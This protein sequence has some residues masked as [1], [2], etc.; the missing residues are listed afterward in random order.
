MWKSLLFV[1]A[2][3]GCKKQEAPPASSSSGSAGSGSVVGPGSVV[4]PSA[5]PD[6]AASPDAVAALD[7]GATKTGLLAPGDQKHGCFAWSA[8]TRSVACMVGT[9]GLGVGGQ[10]VLAV[11][12]TTVTVVTEANADPNVP[13]S[14]PQLAADGVDYAHE[15]L[16]KGGFAPLTGAPQ[17]VT[18][19][20]L[21]LNGVAF[22]LTAKQTRPGGRMMPPTMKHTLTATCGG[23]P[24]VLEQ[25]EIEG[26]TLKA[27]VRAAGTDHVV[28]EIDGNI[29][30]EGERSD[31]TIAQLFDVKACKG[32]KAASP[33][34]SL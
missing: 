4:N 10:Y 11:V 33:T 31:T 29:G 24:I 6:V 9:T 26:L 5:P 16:A 27:N 1:V 8:T 21:E 17:A 12:G 14:P 22:T 30:R 20:Q 18:D 23:K 19:K 32:V 15:E 25:H 13:G 7:A 34:S 3:S 2:V 28:V